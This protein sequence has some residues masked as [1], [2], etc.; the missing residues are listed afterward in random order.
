MAKK[1]N[2]SVVN[3]GAAGFGKN[4]A[5]LTKRIVGSKIGS[6]SIT[7]AGSILGASAGSKIMRKKK[8]GVIRQKGGQ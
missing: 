6:Y 5:D 1:G 3:I 8:G 4:L 7:G 2:K